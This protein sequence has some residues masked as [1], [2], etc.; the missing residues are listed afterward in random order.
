MYYTQKGTCMPIFTHAAKATNIFTTDLRQARLGSVGGEK[1][2]QTLPMVAAGSW[3]AGRHD[4]QNPVFDEQ[5]PRPPAT[6]QAIYPLPWSIQSR[7]LIHPQNRNSKLH[8]TLACLVWKFTLLLLPF[9]RVHGHYMM[10]VDIRWMHTQTYA[11]ASV[12]RRALATSRIQKGS[13]TCAHASQV[14]ALIGR[15]DTTGLLTLTAC[16]TEE[17]LGNSGEDSCTVELANAAASSLADTHCEHNEYVLR[18][19]WGGVRAC[20]RACVR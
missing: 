5:M 2:G 18:L 17:G 20:V 19:L 8:T 10:R 11:Y 1:R 6:S 14:W 13:R 7:H 16:S 15:N 4:N 3:S 12:C 9:T